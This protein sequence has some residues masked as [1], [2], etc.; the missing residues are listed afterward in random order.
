MPDHLCTSEHCQ[1]FYTL[2]HWCVWPAAVPHSECA[3]CSEG[4]GGWLWQSDHQ[5]NV[6]GSLSAACFRLGQAG[7]PRMRSATTHQYRYLSVLVGWAVADGHMRGRQGD[8]AKTCKRVW[9][10]GRVSK[11]DGSWTIQRH[12]RNTRACTRQIASFD[13]HCCSFASCSWIRLRAT[14]SEDFSC[15]L[16]SRITIWLSLARTEGCLAAP[17]STPRGSRMLTGL[18]CTAAPDSTD[19]VAADSVGKLR[20]S[21]RVSNRRSR[22]SPSCVRSF[23]SVATALCRS[24]PC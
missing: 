6:A 18:C 24:V 20:L 14:E 5:L 12:R 13:A 10:H 17:P 23:V 19:V 21:K 22:L 2:V 7:Y 11:H 4:S 1:P 16:S 9:K 8:P 15:G 3:R